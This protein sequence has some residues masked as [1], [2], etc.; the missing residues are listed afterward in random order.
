MMRRLSLIFSLAAC[1]VEPAVGDAALITCGAASDCPEGFECRGNVSRCVSLDLAD[2]EPPEILTSAV[3]PELGS[4]DTT[5]TVSLV[6]DEPTGAV[7]VLEVPGAQVTLVAS[8]DRSCVFAVSDAPDGASSLQLTLLDVYGNQATVPAGELR[9]DG[10][11][12]TVTLLDWVAAPFEATPV[13]VL[14]FSAVLDGDAH[15]TSARLLDDGG[16]E[17][18]GPVRFA[19]RLDA[20]SGTPVVRLSGSVDLG[21]LGVTAAA[22]RVELV[23][24][25]DLGNSSG[26]AQTPALAVDVAPPDTRITS[27]PSD[28]DTRLRAAFTFDSPDNDAVT[29]T[30]VLDGE[31]SACASPFTRVLM[32]DGPHSFSV[33]A[34]D[35]A[36]LT[37]DSPAAHTWTTDRRWRAGA[38]ALAGNVTC[39]IASD[40]S[41]WCWGGNIFGATGQGVIFGSLVTTPA[42][43]GTVAD[44]VSLA[45]AQSGFLGDSSVCG[46]R[47]DGGRNSTWCWGANSHGVFGDNT[48][49]AA[50][51]PQA[52]GT[53]GWRALSMGSA[54]GCGVKLDGSLWCWG[55]NDYGRLGDDTTR[56]R[57]SPV[58]VGTAADWL[59]VSASNSH[60]CGIRAPG[61]L[62]CWGSNEH[63]KL[64]DPAVTDLEA[65][66][67]VHVAGG[68]WAEV[69]AA[70]TATCGIRDDGSARRLVCF[71]SWGGSSDEPA[72]IEVDPGPGWENVRAASST[73][74]GVRDGEMFCFGSVPAAVLSFGAQ[75]DGAIPFLSQTP[76]VAVTAP[77]LIATGVPLTRV[78]PSTDYACGFTADNELLCWGDDTNAELGRGSGSRGPL[79]PASVTLP[80]TPSELSAGRANTC[81]RSSSGVHCWGQ[82][83]TFLGTTGSW[84]RMPVH[85]HSGT[86]WVDLDAERTCGIREPTAGQRSL[87]CWSGTGSAPAVVG[88]ATDWRMV[89]GGRIDN[90][91]SRCGIRGVGATATLW[92]WGSN[93]GGRIGLGATTTAASPTQVGAGMPYQDAWSHVALGRGFGCGIRAPGSLWCWGENASGQLGNATQTGSTVPIQIGGA[94]DWTRVAAGGATTCG[95]RGTGELWCWG[96]NPAILA[97]NDLSLRTS[98]TRVGSA[99]DWSDV[100]LGSSHACGVRGGDL[101]C[102][103]SNSEGLLGQPVTEIYVLAPRQMSYAGV[104]ALAAGASHTCVTHA[105]GTTCFGVSN[106]GQLG[107]G[108]PWG[109]GLLE[110]P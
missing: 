43:V 8:A 5:F 61:E 38:L 14:A 42:R 23:V 106:E 80:A 60:A 109:P 83:T 1:A 24:E 73:I 13:S 87:W 36:G 74:C 65:H 81:A 108:E 103:G 99:A 78:W 16:A 19:T 10:T 6:F 39:A 2:R 45:A 82:V 101:W 21:E 57:L 76:F 48:L 7:P 33:S 104:T 4:P 12:P 17:I 11:A 84:R 29:F 34:T 62:W 67:P 28:G 53:D 15:V 22:V 100:V 46:I 59:A 86:D 89:T 90:T 85:V 110:E 27:S 102:W 26:P 47:D 37:D 56:A 58:R 70:D 31:S 50:T 30:C 35:D 64:G 20:S 105:A 55:D 98:P 69:A 77:Q 51:V 96:D 44:W 107:S 97:T 52:T 25:D 3:E 72:P 95:L 91:V 18:T 88:S 54:F 71:G 49:T 68:D 66:T 41:L 94:T 93:S 32:N 40:D 9:V 75:R 92:C 79:P 63:A